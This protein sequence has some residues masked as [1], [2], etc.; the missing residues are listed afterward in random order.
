MQVVGQ[1]SLELCLV[2][3]EHP[4]NLRTIA[5]QEEKQIASLGSRRSPAARRRIFVMEGGLRDNGSSGSV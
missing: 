1:Y 5:K 4:E 3:G 2:K